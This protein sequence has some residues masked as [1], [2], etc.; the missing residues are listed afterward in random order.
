LHLSNAV[1]LEGDLA[2]KKI[3]KMLELLKFLLP[4]YFCYSSPVNIIP[5]LVVRGVDGAI[6]P[7]PPVKRGP[8][9]CNRGAPQGVIKKIFGPFFI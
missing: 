5:R 2:P 3:L 1:I 8:K 4:S 9:I 7:G 6:C